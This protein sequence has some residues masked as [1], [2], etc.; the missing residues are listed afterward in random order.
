MVR[1]LRALDD[2]IEMAIHHYK[3]TEPLTTQRRLAL[4][5]L[6]SVIYLPELICFSFFQRRSGS[7]TFYLKW[8][9]PHALLSNAYLLPPILVKK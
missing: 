2:N 5:T 4:T 1:L 6:C 3:E 7:F 8:K 9:L